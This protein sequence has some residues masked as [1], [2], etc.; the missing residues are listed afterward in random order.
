MREFGARIRRLPVD[1][2]DCLAFFSRLPVGA[3]TTLSDF[4]VSAAAWPLAGGIIVLIPAALLSLCLYVNLPGLIAA[5]ITLAAVV[6]IT[7]GLHE[8]A[9]ADTADGFGGGT[10]K[11]SRLEIM[12]D[13]RLGAY[14]ALA[15][16]FSLILRIVS[17]AL[18]AVN[19]GGVVA[20][21]GTALLSR[22]LA[23]WHWSTLPP[24]R[25]DGLAVSAGQ[26]DWRALSIGGGLGAIAL[27]V[28]IIG[29]GG[30]SIFALI[31]ATIAVFLFTRLTDSQVGGHTGDT[32]GAAQQIAETALLVGLAA[33][34]E[35][36]PG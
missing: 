8:D 10:S 26:P 36:Y 11:D 7:G 31:A 9:L 33:G 15:L 34:W 22:S 24:A 23:L 19:G 29:I 17:L 6:A 25:D 16:I 35:S 5:T 18:I 14:G 32:I 20:L 21:F 2:R 13:S 30:T 4:R 12:R 27:V 28:L 1:T 3:G